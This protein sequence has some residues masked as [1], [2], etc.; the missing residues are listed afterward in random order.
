VIKP[1]IHYVVIDHLELC[2]NWLTDLHSIQVDF[3][4]FKLLN[5][6]FIVHESEYY[7]YH[8]IED[9]LDY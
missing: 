2:F 9:L 4:N 3:T 5:R 8:L 1:Q 6:C 7:L